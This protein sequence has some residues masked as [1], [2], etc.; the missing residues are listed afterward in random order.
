VVRALAFLNLSRLVTDIH[1][2]LVVQ[3]PYPDRQVNIE[4]SNGDDNGRKEHASDDAEDRGAYLA[5]PIAPNP[6]SSS[7][8]KQTHPSAAGRVDTTVTSG[9][10]Q[11]K[12]HLM[13]PL[14][15]K[16]SKSLVD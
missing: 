2:S 15:H 4:L 10:G 7:V 3:D 11:K 1:V 13:P 5:E 6:I 8:A 12:K 9:S 14:K 16:P